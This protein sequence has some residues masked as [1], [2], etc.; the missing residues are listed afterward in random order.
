MKNKI[1]LELTRS[2]KG[3]DNAFTFDLEPGQRCTLSSLDAN[4]M[5]PWPSSIVRLVGIEAKHPLTTNQSKRW[6]ESHSKLSART[7]LKASGTK[8]AGVGRRPSRPASEICSGEE[9]CDRMNAITE[10]A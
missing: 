5:P 4:E 6:T 9:E 7:Y 1:V 10:R 3:K 8:H 2:L